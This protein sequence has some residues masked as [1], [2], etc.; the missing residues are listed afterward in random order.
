MI[1]LC[2]WHRK[3][4]KTMSRDLA[5]L[6]DKIAELPAE[7]QREFLVFGQGFVAGIELA[8][9]EKATKEQCPEAEDGG[10]A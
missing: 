6:V 8:E 3:E 10:A 9:A 7:K 2:Q 1:S 4:E 5:E